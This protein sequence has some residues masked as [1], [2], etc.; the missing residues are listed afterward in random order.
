[1][2]GGSMK[3]GDALALV[4]EEARAAG[5]QEADAIWEESESLS[6]DAFEGKVQ[7]LERSDSAG[8]GL[9]ALVDGKPGYSFT[10]RLAPEAVRRCARDAV[11]LARFTDPIGLHLPELATVA[12]TPPSADLGLWNPAVEGFDPEAML[13]SCLAAETR[14]RETDPRVVNIPHLG[15]SRSTGRT[16]LANSKGF[17]G[18][19]RS[20]S[21]SFGIGV[22]SR[23]DGIDKMG[24]D[25]ISWRDPSR[26]DPEGLAREAVERSVELLGA[27]PIP[28]GPVPVLFD[29]RIAAQFLSIFLGAFLADAVQKGQSRLVG[30]LG[31]R[32]APRGF[33]LSTQPHLAGMSGSRFFDGEGLPTSPRRLVDDGILGGFLHN[34]ETA[35]RDGIAPTGDAVRSYTGRV[36]AG[37]SNLQV[38]LA[39]GRSN[40]SLEQSFPRVLHVVKLEGS[41]GCNPISGD[42]S[43]GVQGF[44]VQGASRTPVDR[45]S[46]SGNIFE[47]LSDLVGWGDNYRPGVRSQFVPCLLARSLQL[48][49]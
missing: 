41:T 12:G 27:R 15:A 39:G 18:E 25:G 32:L 11:A 10:E 29:E 49:S 30:R 34:L 14:A 8:L 42:I 43:I 5:A 24:W 4:L 44:L 46:L 35:T 1:M 23:Q 31:Q 40:A 36:A 6:L 20:G 22:V 9:R 37:F 48:A 47:T 2:N 7:N 16:L 13:D 3:P 21:A 45:V 17:L 33:H 19:R 28:S 26:L 38:E